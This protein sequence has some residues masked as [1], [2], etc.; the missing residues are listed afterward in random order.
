[1]EWQQA[2]HFSGVGDKVAVL[3]EEKWYYSIELLTLSTTE[4]TPVMLNQVPDEKT[5]S[6]HQDIAHWG[7]WLLTL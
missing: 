2:M 4:R 7:S 3:Y 6:K 1:M 5:L